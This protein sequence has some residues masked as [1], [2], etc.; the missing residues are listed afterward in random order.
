MDALRQ[1]LT[2]ALAN[3]ELRDLPPSE[4]RAGVT[5]TQR[6]HA[7][8]LCYSKARAVAR[9]GPELIIFPSARDYRDNEL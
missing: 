6:H 2:V 1:G 8:L 7:W 4:S 5:G 3:L 9:P